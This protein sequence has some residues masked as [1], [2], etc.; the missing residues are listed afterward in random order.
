MTRILTTAAIVGGLTM[1]AAAPQSALADQVK[2]Y[3]SAGEKVVIDTG[4]LSGCVTVYDSLNRPF[5][6][7]RL[8][9]VPA[10]STTTNK[11]A[12]RRQDRSTARRVYRRMERRN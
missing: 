5:E 1:A 11:A 12:D 3:N 7:C 2:L 10:A 4:L 9:P 6:F 8:E